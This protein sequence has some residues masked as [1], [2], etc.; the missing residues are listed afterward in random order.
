MGYLIC[1]KWEDTT[2]SNQK[3]AGRLHRVSVR[4]GINI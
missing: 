4:W 1:K 2:N 3:K